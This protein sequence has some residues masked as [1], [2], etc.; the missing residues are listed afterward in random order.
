MIILKPPLEVLAGIAFRV[1][2]TGFAEVVFCAV[3]TAVQ[4]RVWLP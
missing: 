3:S 1:F 2:D 4:V